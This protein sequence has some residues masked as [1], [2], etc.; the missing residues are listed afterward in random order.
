MRLVT[1]I[2][3]SAHERDYVSKHDDIRDREFLVVGQW[4]KSHWYLSP[5]ID[6][7]AWNDQRR[8]CWANITYMSAW[9]S[10]WPEWTQR[11]KTYLKLTDND[12]NF[13]SHSF[14]FH[15]SKIRKPIFHKAF[16]FFFLLN[17]ERDL[18]ITY[19]INYKY[20]RKQET[21]Y[22]NFNKFKKIWS[23]SWNLHRF[24]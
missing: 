12:T 7:L 10:A 15:N 3:D 2:V 9:R 11:I 21:W 22:L 1:R 18:K 8:A 16:F 5:A 13:S 4:E 6:T 14:H 20:K 17:I 24:V 19:K 23:F